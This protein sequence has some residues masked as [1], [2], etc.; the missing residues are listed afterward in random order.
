MDRESNKSDCHSDCYYTVHA[1]YNIFKMCCAVLHMKRSHSKCVSL[2]H[3]LWLSRK[4]R[5]MP[6]CTSTAHSHSRSPPPV[7][8]HFL[9]KIRKWDSI[10]FL[11]LLHRLT[12]SA[13]FFIR[14]CI[15]VDYFDI[16]LYRRIICFNFCCKFTSFDMH[17]ICTM[18]R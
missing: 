16:T 5:R 14:W 18:H 17:S 3:L 2:S 4:C 7:C 15:Q 13:P 12:T 8:C 1:L 6:P 11:L 10:S 9:T